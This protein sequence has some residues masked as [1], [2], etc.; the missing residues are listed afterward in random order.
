MKTKHIDTTTRH[1]IVS[2]CASVFVSS[3]AYGD[4]S[5]G[6]IP[7]NIGNPS[8]DTNL[9][10][11]LQNYFTAQKMIPVYHMML[12]TSPLSLKKTGQTESYDEDGNIVAD[13]SI[14]DDG[15]YQQG[16]VPIY[17]RDANKEVVI[18]KITGLMWQD[19]SAAKTIQTTWNDAKSYCTNLTL[20]NYNDWRLPSIDEMMYIF[21]RHYYFP[22]IDMNYFRNINGA[23]SYWTS[24]IKADDNTLAWT[25]NQYHGSDEIDKTSQNHYVRCVRGNG[26]LRHHYVRNN[27][28]E[29]VTDTD[30]GLMWQDNADAKTVTGSWEEAID[31]CESLTLGG[32]SDWRLP[33]FYELYYLADRSKFDPSLSSVF[34]NSLSNFYWS[35][36]AKA[37]DTSYAW[38]V[39]FYSGYDYFN[40]KTGNMYIRCV[41]GG[42]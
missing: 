38:V 17:T 35:S 41:R 14:K 19:D 13:G 27:G 1:R 15:Y 10:Q 25:T 2:L 12:L 30:T 39:N 28:T 16:V 8:F 37:E 31:Y 24:S 18:D 20:E 32:Y 3:L 6:G 7:D 5:L 22:A 26:T 42:Q 23:V 34:Q 33:N 40:N 11:A 4:F 29:T 36:T 9:I 21:D